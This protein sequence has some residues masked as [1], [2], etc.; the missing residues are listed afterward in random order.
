MST[1]AASAQKLEIAHKDTSLQVLINIHEKE[2]KFVA[3]IKEVVG[4]VSLPLRMGF[5]DFVGNEGQQFMSIRAPL[6]T[7]DEN[8]EFITRPRQKGGKF[9]SDTGAEVASEAEAAR[10]YVYMVQKNDATKLVYAQIATLNVKNTKS[11]NTPTAMT[12]ISAKV[13]SDDEALAAE[14]I[15]FTMSRVGKESPDYAGMAEELKAQRR[16]AGTWHNFFINA[17]ADVLRAKG[18]EVREKARSQAQEPSL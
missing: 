18:F 4:G 8:G 13:F 5:L 7:K 14:R 17:G 9:L 11:D 2:G 12:M 6:R 16:G 1:P 10:E 3:H 15:S